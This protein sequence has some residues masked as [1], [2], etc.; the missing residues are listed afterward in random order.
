MSQFQDWYLSDLA[1]FED[2]AWP[3]GPQFAS[4]NKRR[5]DLSLTATWQS[6]S[7]SLP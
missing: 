3:L 1:S 4:S 5:Q 6:F 7:D 2:L